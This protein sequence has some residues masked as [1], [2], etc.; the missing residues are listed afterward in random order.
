MP[1]DTR[2]GIR[3][4]TRRVKDGWPAHGMMIAASI[5]KHK[6]SVGQTLVICKVLSTS[7][8]KDQR[9]GSVSFSSGFFFEVCSASKLP[10]KANFAVIFTEL[11]R[12]NLLVDIFFLLKM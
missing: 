8:E 9:G 1:N 6:S 12:F 4:V 10:P 7:Y 2:E 11:N 3:R 5:R